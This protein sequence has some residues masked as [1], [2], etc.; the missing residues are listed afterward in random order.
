MTVAICEHDTDHGGDILLK[1]ESDSSAI[2]RGALSAGT[3][4]SDG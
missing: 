4:P 3:A 1:S 2:D